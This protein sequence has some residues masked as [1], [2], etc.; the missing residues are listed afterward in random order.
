M[1]RTVMAVEPPS[2]SSSSVIVVSISSNHGATAVAAATGRGRH[3]TMTER[4]RLLE[5][6]CEEFLQANDTLA[7]ALECASGVQQQQASISVSTTTTA[8][9]NPLAP[10]CCQPPQCP[11][12][13]HVVATTSQQPHLTTTMAT[14]PQSLLL[15]H[16]DHSSSRHRG[17][18]P[19][20]K[21][22]IAKSSTMPACHW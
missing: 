10:H 9:T 17:V 15:Q 1:T 16:I 2:S 3:V 21:S 11:P 4:K 14:T 6:Q 19:I 12:M 22:C 5:Q 7:L 8:T 13:D 18:H 20:C